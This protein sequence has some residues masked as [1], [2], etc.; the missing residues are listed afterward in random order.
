MFAHFG[1]HSTALQSAAGLGAQHS[2]SRRS[3]ERSEGS[4]SSTSATSSGRKAREPSTHARARD[5]QGNE[6]AQGND[7]HE[8]ARHGDVASLEGLLADYITKYRQ[9][10]EANHDGNTPL[11]IAAH[12]G[13]RACVELLL[14][15]N[16][17]TDVHNNVGSTPLLVAA[18]NGH[19][20]CV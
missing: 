6:P 9:L 11:L 15:E 12:Y 1:P 20:S 4:A 16:A 13:Q 14:K 10:N 8:A 17:K 5:A 7:M 3:A 2:A 18:Y 19:D